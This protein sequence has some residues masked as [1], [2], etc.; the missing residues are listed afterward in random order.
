MG[1]DHTA[2]LTGINSEGLRPA[3]SRCKA[4]DLLHRRRKGD[5]DGGMRLLESIVDRQGVQPHVHKT[6]DS[7]IISPFPVIYTT[8]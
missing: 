7:I 6:Q 4:G 5:L 8:R 3:E 1:A 2:V